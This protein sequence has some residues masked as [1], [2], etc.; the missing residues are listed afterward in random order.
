MQMASATA[1]LF[2][3]ASYSSYGLTASYAL[4][5]SGTWNSASYTSPSQSVAGFGVDG[6]AI[7]YTPTQD[8]VY[9]AKRGGTISWVPIET[10]FSAVSYADNQEY[11]DAM[12]Q[13]V[14]YS[15]PNAIMHTEEA[16]TETSRIQEVYQFTERE[17]TDMLQIVM[18]LTSSVG[19]FISGE[20]FDTING[21]I[22]TSGSISHIALIDMSQEFSHFFINTSGSMIYSN[23]Y[24]STIEYANS[25]IYITSSMQPL[26]TTTSFTTASI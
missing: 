5:V 1:S 21:I 2:G 12:S 3:T 22:N 18:N 9:L 17:H 26:I 25:F 15:N 6:R 10:K 13:S 20:S 19:I 11:M 4:N 7:L 14:N 8:N 24:D 16:Q 23:T